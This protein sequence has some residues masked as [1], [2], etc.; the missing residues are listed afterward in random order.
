MRFPCGIGGSFLP[1]GRESTLP[2]DETLLCLK[3]IRFWR[4]H[5][6]TEGSA[7]WHS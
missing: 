5:P 7:P 4:F 6:L 3:E 2:T 1:K